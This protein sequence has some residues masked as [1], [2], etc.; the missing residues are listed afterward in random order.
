MDGWMRVA[1]VVL[2]QEDQ[3]GSRREEEGKGG[4]MEKDS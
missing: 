4:Y 3:M 1:V 2:E